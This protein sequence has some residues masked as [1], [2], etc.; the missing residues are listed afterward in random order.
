MT[1]FNIANWKAKH[2]GKNFLTGCNIDVFSNFGEEG[3]EAGWRAA[4]VMVVV[5]VVVEVVVVHC[6][7]LP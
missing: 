3:G 4:V 1:T 2:D 5:V 6:T 7:L